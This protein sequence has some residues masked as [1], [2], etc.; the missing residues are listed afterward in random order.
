MIWW[1]FYRHRNKGRG[2]TRIATRLIILVFI[3]VCRVDMIMKHTKN[4]RRVLILI[5]MLSLGFASIV[6]AQEGEDDPL[7]PGAQIYAANCAMCHGKNGEGRVGATLAKDWPSIRPDLASKDTIVNGV[8][9]SPMPAWSQDNG[10]PLSDQEIEAVVTYILS[11]QTGGVPQITP[12]HTLTPRPAISP[13]PGVE[14]NPDQGVVLYNENCRVCHG[15]NGE[16]RIGATLAKPW[17]SIRPDLAIRSTIANGVAG[18]PMPA[19]SQENGGPLNSEE[20]DHLTAFVI[21]W[22][23]PQNTQETATPAEQPSSPFLAWGGIFLTIGLFLLIITL[24]WLF[25]NKHR[26]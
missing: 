23:V 18:S 16:G 7:Q 17:P 6:L 20:I 13:V 11:W 9:G 14:G 10:G 12:A 4:I 24:I 8:A 2:R 25:Q 15:K 1:F 22:P 3:C 5:L 21:S 19:W 26:D